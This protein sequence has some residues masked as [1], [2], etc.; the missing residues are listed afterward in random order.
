MRFKKIHEDT[1]GEIA[2]VLDILPGDRELT[3]FTTNK[4]YARGGCV[5][6]HNGEACVVIKGAILYVI[7]NNEPLNLS[8]GD[9]CYIEPNTPHYFI[10]LTN[11]TVVLE[12]GATEEE[13]K[14]RDPQF[15]HIV[16]TINENMGASS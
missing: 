15:R 7:G 14:E 13:K 2:V 16:D 10:A 4:G 6:R 11:E 12:W 5:H 9:T 3:I 1:R 8:C